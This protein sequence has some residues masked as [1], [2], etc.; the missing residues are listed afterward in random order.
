MKISYDVGFDGNNLQFLAAN[1]MEYY[2]V[3]P[4]MMARVVDV[5]SFLKDSKDSKTRVESGH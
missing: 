4:E 5:E 3:R 2:Q 1:P